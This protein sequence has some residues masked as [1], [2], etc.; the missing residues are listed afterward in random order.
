[1]RL[2]GKIAFVTGA[3][4]GIGRGCALELA[5]DGADVV[6][7]DLRAS[8][9]A[10]AVVEEIGQLGRRAALVTGDVFQRASCEQVA[11]QAA[12]ALGP[13]DILVSNPA[14][15]R[16]APFLEY[17][18]ETFER[19]LQGTLAA[20]FHMSQLVARQL[21]ARQARG[22]IIFIASLHARVP[23]ID[24]VAY[25]AAKRGL[26]AMGET[27]AAELLPYRIN[28]NMIEPGWIDTPGERASFGDQAVDD[29]GQR[30]P[31]GRLGHPEDI[32]RV[33]AFL[34]SEDA[35]YMT[36]ASLL[37][38]GGLWLRAATPAATPPRD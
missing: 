20:G 26:I 15:S 32:G 27:I 8:D 17:D 29:G 10:S 7:N 9:E 12:A 37:V 23:F 19:T 11:E 25:N 28:V 38:D 14:F 18:P 4:R 31:W 6:I 2:Q 22:K 35:D 16:R 1:V 30:L 3:A 21:V 13:L 36:G 33:A 34:A 24:S 5:R